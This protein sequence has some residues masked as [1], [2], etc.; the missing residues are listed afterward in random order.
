VA[1]KSL[2]EKFSFNII[3]QVVFLCGLCVHPLCALCV[4][5]ISRKERKDF[6][7]K[8]RKENTIVSLI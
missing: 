7:Y 4:K 2:I 1:K 3:T 6:K 5:Y 8:E